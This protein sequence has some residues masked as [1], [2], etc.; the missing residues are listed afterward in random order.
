MPAN[1]S[2]TVRDLLTFRMGFGMIMGPPNVYPIQ[3]AMAE[4]G[5]ASGPILPSLA[6]DEWMKRLGSLP[7]L[8]QPGEKWMYHTGSDILGVLIARAAGQKLETFFRERLFEPLGMKDTGF[9]VPEGSSTGWRPAT[10]SMPRPAS[11]WSSLKRAPTGGPALLSSSPAAA[12]WYRRS[13]IIS[14]S[15]G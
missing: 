8:H 14:P 12:D 11:L 6:P 4:A 1:R 2:V 9:S 13:T 3:V 7:L 15:A 5:V 10:R